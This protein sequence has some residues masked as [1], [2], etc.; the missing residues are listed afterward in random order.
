MMET[1]SYLGDGVYVEWDGWG[2]WLHANDPD[3]P[4]DSI[5]LEPEVFDSLVDFFKQLKQ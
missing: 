4:T 1:K 3:E 5:Y 2:V